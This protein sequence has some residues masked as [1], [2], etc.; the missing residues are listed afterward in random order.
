MT[1]Q[2]EIRALAER[3]APM[4]GRH[5]AGPIDSRGGL[6]DY[7]AHGVIVC[8][9][10]TQ[11]VALPYGPLLSSFNRLSGH[12]G[13]PIG[14]SQDF[15]FGEYYGGKAQIMRCENGVYIST[16]SRG[17]SYYLPLPVFEAWIGAP[18]FFLDEVGFNLGY[19][20]GRH[21]RAEGAVI[22][23]PFEH[24]MVVVDT[25]AAIAIVLDE[26][27]SVRDVLIESQ[28][29]TAGT[30]IRYKLTMDKLRCV[31]ETD[32][33]GSDEVFGTVMMSEPGGNHVAQ[34]REFDV[35]T[36]EERLLAV[37][38]YDG[39]LPSQFFISALG[40]EADDEGL[41]RQSLRDF[42]ARVGTVD[43]TLFESIRDSPLSGEDARA[44]I[45]FSSF[46]GIG[47]GVALFG[48][49]DVV[50]IVS[51]SSVTLSVGGWAGAVAAAVVAAAFITIAIVDSLGPDPIMATRS[52]LQGAGILVQVARD[53]IPP[54]NP[55]LDMGSDIVTS[56]RNNLTRFERG[57]TLEQ[58]H[59]YRNRAEDS[60][61][62]VTL[63]HRISW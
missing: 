27:L 32:G 42:T 50:I 2:D 35:D 7:Y 43:A 16:E 1:C 26:S 22:T 59:W 11:A 18:R 47:V 45:A 23:Q 30:D 10:S 40:L 44:L 34:I 60:T 38:I 20:T 51:G 57:F 49:G 4:L 53:E 52:L 55:P 62:E 56:V 33:L 28:R 41:A 25:E 17:G 36:N 46:V 6:M 61:Y 13:Y 8:K 58:T 15:D 39:P 19:P 31:E 29:V 9:E 3:E 63:Q 21:K 5:L 48:A 12:S 24:G 14:P 54:G 37:Q